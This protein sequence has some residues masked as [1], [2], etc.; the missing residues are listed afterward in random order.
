MSSVGQTGGREGDR[1]QQP[2]GGVPGAAVVAPAASHGAQAVN[3]THLGV[4]ITMQGVGKK[5]TESSQIGNSRI[6]KLVWVSSE[7]E[8]LI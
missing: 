1:E 6:T 3:C 4:N 2:P 8:K 5:S 7:Y